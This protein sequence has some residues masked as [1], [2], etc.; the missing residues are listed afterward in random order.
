MIKKRRQGRLHKYALC[1]LTT[2][3]LASCASSRTGVPIDIA[4]TITP[5]AH[6]QVMSERRL[7]AD[8]VDQGLSSYALIRRFAGPKSIES[9]DL[10]AHNHP[11]G[12]HIYEA[13]DAVVGDHF[14]FTLHKAHD[15]DRG[16]LSITDR[17]R[18]E[19]KAY[20]GS[21]EDL[22]AYKN[23]TFTYSWKF[24]LNNDI[25]LSRHFG[26]FF[27]LKAVDGGPGAPILTISARDK[28]GEWLEIIHRIHGKS[29][30][31]KRV[32]LA[33]FK[34][35]WLQI[36][37]FVN[38]SNQGA[39]TLR[40]TDIVSGEPL[41]ALSL[42][43]IDMLR[44]ESSTDFVRPKW[45]IYRSLKSKEMLREEEEKVF[46]ADFIVQRLQAK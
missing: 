10:Y 41:L 19:I 42:Q 46:F 38:Y 37:C 30:K 45:G 23:E 36:N 24:K 26:H 11:Q 3:L 43:D 35:R 13:S 4:P 34:G 9:P 16:I 2:A 22:K 25:T 20:D 15:N 8:G 40:I 32:P 44:G 21:S 1:I 17:Q 6:F 14:V 28:Q 29:D 7:N 31:L 39:L 12:E 27:Q 5:D 33:P 18:N